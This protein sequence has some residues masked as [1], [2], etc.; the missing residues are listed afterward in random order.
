E[1]HQGVPLA[2]FLLDIVLAAEAEGVGPVGVAAIPVDAA[3]GEGL[4]LAARLVVRLRLL[5]R[6]RLAHLDLALD[7]RLVLAGDE[8]DVAG[9]ALD[10]LALDRF[11]PRAAG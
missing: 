10:H 9:A 5:A 4:Q 11:H 3:A 7:G 1:D 6:R 8:D 2:G